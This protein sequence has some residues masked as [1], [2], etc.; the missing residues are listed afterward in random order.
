MTPLSGQRGRTSAR[1]YACIAAALLGVAAVGGTA[2]GQC[3]PQQLIPAD[4]EDS[5]EFSRSVDCDGSTLAIG[6]PLDDVVAMDAG[7]VRIF[8]QQ[9]GV[10]TQVQLI[11]PADGLPG[12]RF[13]SCVSISGD[14]LVVGAPNFSDGGL[15]RGTVYVYERQGGTWTFADKLLPSELAP[16][17]RLGTSVAVDGD[18]LVAGAPFDG[19][20]GPKAGAAYVY[21][22]VG[23]TWTK[24]VKLFP[25][26][27]DDGDEFGT[28]VSISGDRMLIGAPRD[29]VNGIDSG[30]V[31]FFARDAQQMWSPDGTVR[32][33]VG[34]AGFLFGSA[35]D[36]DG[37]VAVI[38]AHADNTQDVEAGAAHIFNRAT[39]SWTQTIKLTP[40]DLAADDHFGHAVALYGDALLIGTPNQDEFGNNAGAVYR[41]QNING[42]WQLAQKLSPLELSAGDRFGWSVALNDTVLVTSAISAVTNGDI[43]GRAHVFDTGAACSCPADLVPPAGV[44]DVFDMFELLNNWG[45]SGAGADLAEPTDVIDVF[46]LFGLLNAWGFCSN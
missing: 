20:L 36:L 40:A 21:Q 29:R 31:H 10:W 44:V 34:S 30:A 4:L 28:T 42:T 15:G 18:T 14:N 45:T 41:F 33:P 1:P 16:G 37:T 9:S 5:D 35:I 8:E 25:T 2:C 38:G 3:N 22:R 12:D 13:G 43:T 17:D 24:I 6:A 46:D 26:G 32:P 23:G 39:R 27:G 11:A 7:S 19:L